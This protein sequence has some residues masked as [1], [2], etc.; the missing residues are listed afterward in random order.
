MMEKVEIIVESSKTEKTKLGT[1]ETA[2][3]YIK[4]RVNENFTVFVNSNSQKDKIIEQIRKQCI[5][6]LRIN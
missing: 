4:R 2:V 3:E 1:L 5:N 6:V